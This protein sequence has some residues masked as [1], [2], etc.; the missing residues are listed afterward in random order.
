ML[1]LEQ[2]LPLHITPTKI[3][4]RHYN[5]FHTC[6][7]ILSNPG[8]THSVSTAFVMNAVGTEWVTPG[9]LR[10]T[11]C[12]RIIKKYSETGYNYPLLYYPHAF[13][14]KRRGY[15]NRLRPSVCLSVRLSFTLSPSK[16]LDEI[17]PN[18]VCVLLT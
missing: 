5:C 18:L 2:M 6:F 7:V 8:V 9:L 4:I 16:P 10:M 15:C 17:Q 12:M 1:I 14:K 11:L 3:G 13:L